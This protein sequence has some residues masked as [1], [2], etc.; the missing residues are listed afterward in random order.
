MNQD[1]VQ[2]DV[3]LNQLIEDITQDATVLT[4]SASEFYKS[5]D[6]EKPLNNPE[7]VHET[8]IFKEMCAKILRLINRVNSSLLND[9]DLVLLEAFVKEYATYLQ[10]RPNKGEKEGLFGSFKCVELRMTFSTNMS[11]NIA[12]SSHE[13]GHLI[14]CCRND[15]C[16]KFSTLLK[17]IEV[18]EPDEWSQGDILRCVKN[19]GWQ[20]ERLTPKDELMAD[21]IAAGVLRVCGLLDY[22]MLRNLWDRW[23]SEDH[24]ESRVKLWSWIQGHPSEEV[25]WLE[26]AHVASKMFV[27]AGLPFEVFFEKLFP[28]NHGREE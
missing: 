14:N 1:S 17:S 9:R 11:F 22:E 7:R 10:Y 24:Q 28:V 12:A 26:K 27:E 2:A 4:H 8:A 6:A 5:F 20:R 3:C 21:L 13:L 23:S 19:E 18:G 25:N 15:L 16:D